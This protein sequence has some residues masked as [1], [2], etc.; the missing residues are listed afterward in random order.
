MH[1]AAAQR[2]KHQLRRRHAGIAS[3]FVEGLIA[4]HAMEA[5]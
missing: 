5:R 3:P 4:D 1:G 2:R